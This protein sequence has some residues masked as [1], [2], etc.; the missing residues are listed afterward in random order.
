MAVTVYVICYLIFNKIYG[1][2]AL[3]KLFTK[4]AQ[5]DQTFWPSICRPVVAY[6]N[7]KLSKTKQTIRR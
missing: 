1:M 5:D 3:H 7:K 2:G 4:M 6:L